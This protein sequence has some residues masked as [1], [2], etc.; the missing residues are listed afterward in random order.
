MCHHDWHRRERRSEEARD[1]RLWDLFHRETQQ[2]PP[3]VPI[4]ER[5]EQFRAEVERYE[6][7]VER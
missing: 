7:T 2:S 3:P 1:E 4:A 6:V 5:E